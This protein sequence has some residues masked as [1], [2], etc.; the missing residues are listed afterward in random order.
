MHVT[1][2]SP[3]TSTPPPP[4]RTPLP[5]THHRRTYQRPN[6]HPGISTTENNTGRR[7]KRR[8]GTVAGGR[9]PRR[10]PLPTR[11]CRTPSGGEVGVEKKAPSGHPHCPPPLP[12]PAS[13][14]PPAA[15]RPSPSACSPRPQRCRSDPAAHRW[16]PAACATAPPLRRPSAIMASL[17][18]VVESAV[19]GGGRP[20][21]GLSR[22]S[23]PFR[24]LLQC[25]PLHRPSESLGPW[26]PA[27]PQRARSLPTHTPATSD[28]Q[29][30]GI[31]PQDVLGPCRGPNE[32]CRGGG[33]ACESR[34]FRQ[35]DSHQILT[36]IR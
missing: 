12:R 14:K 30:S 8:A 31:K 2:S 3:S 17:G 19:G 13:P 21:V 35:Q 34:D 33:S 15:V 25:P 18:K 26:P 9:H 7:G 10:G 24:L 6:A 23:A 28:T 16:T 20:W 11:W 5:H 4:H 27:R 22:S 32:A 36:R 1:R 29:R